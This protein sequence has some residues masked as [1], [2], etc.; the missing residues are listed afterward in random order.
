MHRDRFRSAGWLTTLVVLVVLAMLA[1]VA[2]CGCGSEE[3]G[4][5]STQ[6]SKSST[7]PSTQPAAGTSG[8]VLLSGGES[9]ASQPFE[10]S[11]GVA[12]FTY[13]YSGTSQ[14]KAVLL[15]STG[16]EVDL[17]IDVSGSVSGSTAVGV[18]GGQYVVDVT[19]T[20]AWEIDVEQASP[21][22]LPYTPLTFSGSSPLATEFFQSPGENASFI[23]NF[24]GTSKFTVTLLNSSGETVN[25]VADVTGPYST[26][27][28][29]PLASGVAYLVD[30]EAVGPWTLTVQ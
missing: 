28:T 9:E 2:G 5:T 4:K 8:P 30:I 12:T 11:K 19:T 14:F 21:G 25:T 23:M 3:K 27:A 18:P 10:L 26:T 6:P 22:V 7:Q 17:L 16:R 29:V 15:D 1:A 13:Q 24:T 20:G